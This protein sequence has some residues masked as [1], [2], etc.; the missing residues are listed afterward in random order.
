MHEC[1]SDDGTV[2]IVC[3]HVHSSFGTVACL[4][5]KNKNKTEKEQ[6]TPF[7]SHFMR[8]LVMY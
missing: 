8:S 4:H 2:H 5:I 3:S 7:G 6:S 1:L